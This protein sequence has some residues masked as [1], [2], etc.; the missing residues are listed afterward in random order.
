MSKKLNQLEA[1]AICGNDI[2]SSCLYV[3]ALAIVYAGQ[4]A[5]IS[6]LMVAVVLYFFRSIYGEVVG[7]LPLNGGAYNAL[8]NTTKKSTASLAATLTVLSYMATAVISASEAVKYAHSIWHVIPILPVTIALLFIFMALVTIGIG[9]SSKVAIVIFLFHLASLVILCGFCIYFF[10]ENGTE[11]LFSNFNTPVKGG[12]VTALFLGF[13]AAMLGISGFESSANYVE[14]QQKGVFPKTLRNMWIVVTVF[15]PLIAFLA[16]AII[17]IHTVV[18]NQDALL[19]VLGET[20]SGNWLS[21]LIG[22]DASLVLSGAVLTSFV[23]VGGLMKRMA[24]DRILPKQ[25]LIKNK[26][27]SNYLIYSLFFI[28]CVSILLITQGDLAKLA[29]IYTIA[30]LSVMMLFGIGNLLLKVNRSRLPRPEKSSWLGL[31]IAVMAVIAAIVGNIILNPEDLG[32]FMEYLIPALGIVFFML[33]RTYIFKIFLTILDYIFPD[34]GTLFRKLNTKTKQL[35]KNINK[36]QFVYFTNHDDVA[37]L[38][39]V[40]LYISNNEA[41]KRVKIVTVLNKD[42]TFAINLKKD[43][44]TLNR[45]YPL[46]DVEFIEE[47]GVFGPEKIK[48]LSKRWNIP[49]NFMFIA[50]PGDKFPYKIQELGEVR[51]II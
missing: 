17:P 11:T 21:L 35:L 24:L 36:Q 43:I 2:S 50:S 19:S 46:I 7:A 39:R 10:I 20:A 30:F 51:L 31:F 25:L 41:T 47:P 33:Y 6:L 15:N 37:T 42:E 40:L 13:S 27:G 16:L 18:A 29:G 23:G 1:T 49:S 3:S 4:Y 8:L 45:A 22:I 14:E 48:E 28:L 9:E 12:I 44:E 5:W 34:K 32:I 38:N 26:K